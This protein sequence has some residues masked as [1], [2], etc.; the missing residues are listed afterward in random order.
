MSKKDFGTKARELAA[1]FRLDWDRLVDA[2]EICD[3]VLAVSLE[4]LWAYRGR[5]FHQ[6]FR[7]ELKSV[8]EVDW[9][10]RKTAFRNMGFALPTHIAKYPN[11]FSDFWITLNRILELIP[12]KPTT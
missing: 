7:N 4:W 12:L 3:E 5:M 2:T 11:Q 8:S 6:S 1:E 9:E 10:E